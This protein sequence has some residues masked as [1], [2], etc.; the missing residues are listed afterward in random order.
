MIQTAIELDD[1]ALYTHTITQAH[2]HAIPDGMIAGLYR[3]HT[4]PCHFTWTGQPH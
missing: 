1:A 3:H 2:T 4:T